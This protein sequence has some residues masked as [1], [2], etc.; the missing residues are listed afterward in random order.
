M[1]LDVPLAREGITTPPLLRLTAVACLFGAEAIHIAVIDEHLSEWLPAGL[2]FVGIALAE[3]LLGVGLLVK[4]TARLRRAAIWV[5]LGTVAV[6]LLSRTAGLPVGPMSGRTEH[7]G[8]SDS[9][10][11]GFELVTAFALLAAGAA[12][13]TASD[14]PGSERQCR[15]A[16]ASSDAC[17][18]LR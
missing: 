15:P 5:S 2:F 3:G 6:W 18:W 8:I 4:P 13:R 7:V 1:A 11:T 12:A 14:P 10:A 17:C 9:V 16:C